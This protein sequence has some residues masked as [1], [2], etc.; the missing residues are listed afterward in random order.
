[1]VY[2]TPPCLAVKLAQPGQEPAEAVLNVP[3]PEEFR[4]PM[5]R[6]RLERLASLA[7]P[8]PV[9]DSTE[10]ILELR[11][12]DAA[13]LLSSFAFISSALSAAARAAPAEMQSDTITSVF[14]ICIV[15]LYA[16]KARFSWAKGPIFGLRCGDWRAVEII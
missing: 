14:V 16:A 10:A 3:F 15:R 7:L 5:L 13:V 2:A 4:L 9:D 1:M 8:R 12:A 6:E 11:L